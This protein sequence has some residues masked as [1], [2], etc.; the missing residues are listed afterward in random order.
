MQEN[1]NFENEH[2]TEEVTAADTA[3]RCSRSTWS[4]MKTVVLPQ[5]SAFTKRSFMIISP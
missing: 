2:F 4:R 5:G 3:A 1:T